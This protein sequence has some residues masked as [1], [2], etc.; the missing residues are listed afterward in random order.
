MD[1]TLNS[2]GQNTGVGSLSLL[3]GIFPTQ[4]SSPGLLHQ[5][6]ILYQLSHKGSPRI[7]ECVAYPFSSGS[8]WP[9]NRTGVSCTADGSFTNWAIK[10]AQNV[11]WYCRILGRRQNVL[12]LRTSLPSLSHKYIICEIAVIYGSP[13]L[14]LLG[15]YKIRRAQLD[16]NVNTLDNQA[17]IANHDFWKPTI[18]SNKKISN[19]F[20]FARAPWKEGPVQL[21]SPEAQQSQRRQIS[22]QKLPRLEDDNG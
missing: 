15:T 19:I 13:C 1:Y 5:R 9:R 17:I 16:T 12:S 6:R 4:G 14:I 22:E 7:L 3:Q 20:P 11:S 21:K 18:I 8:S 10:E 2:P